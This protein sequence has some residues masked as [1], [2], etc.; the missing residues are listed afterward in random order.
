MQ[1]TITKRTDIVPHDNPRRSIFRIVDA[2]ILFSE[3]IQ[4]Q[5]LADYGRLNSVDVLKSFVLASQAIKP[6]NP[7]QWRTG[8]KHHEI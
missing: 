6:E 1:E 2:T 5:V 8:S 7:K 4:L 3:Q